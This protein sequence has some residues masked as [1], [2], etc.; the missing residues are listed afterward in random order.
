MDS[1]H[2]LIYG[3]QQHEGQGDD[4]SPATAVSGTPIQTKTSASKR[5]SKK[6]PRSITRQQREEDTSTILDEPTTPCRFSSRLEALYNKNPSME[7]DTQNASTS[8]A[9]SFIL[10]DLPVSQ[11]RDKD[12]DDDDSYAAHRLRKRKHKEDVTRIRRKWQ[13]RR[14]NLT[15]EEDVGNVVTN[16]IKETL[17]RQEQARRK[18]KVEQNV[19]TGEMAQV[20]DVNESLTE[21][22]Y[23]QQG[24]TVPD[25]VKIA[26]RKMVPAEV[27]NSRSQLETK[28]SCSAKPSSPPSVFTLRTWEKHVAIT[29]VKDPNYGTY[30]FYQP[31]SAADL[32]NTVRSMHRRYLYATTARMI[33][34]NDDD[35]PSSTHI[36][37]NRLLTLL[38]KPPPFKEVDRSTL[39]AHHLDRSTLLQLFVELQASHL[40]F[41]LKRSWSHPLQ[42]LHEL[43]LGASSGCCSNMVPPSLIGFPLNN[44][45]ALEHVHKQLQQKMVQ[46]YGLDLTIDTSTADDNTS[47]LAPTVSYFFVPGSVPPTPMGPLDP[48]NI[49]FGPVDRYNSNVQHAPVNETVYQLTLSTLLARLITARFQG[50]DEDERH[51][52]QHLQCMALETIRLN[53]NKGWKLLAQFTSTGVDEVPLVQFAKACH[54]YCSLVANNMISSSE[55]IKEPNDDD[56]SNDSK[57]SPNVYELIEEWKDHNGLQLFSRL[58]ITFGIFRIHRILPDAAAAMLARPFDAVNCRTPLELMQQLLEFMEDSHMLTGVVTPLLGKQ[59]NVIHVSELEYALYQASEYFAKA[60]DRDPTEPSCHEWHLAVLMG[61]MLLCSGNR[62]E[63]EAR[64]HPSCRVNDQPMSVLDMFGSDERST[65]GTHEIRRMLPKFHRLRQETARA[66]HNLLLLALHQQGARSY[67]AVTSFLEWKQGIALMFGA[68]AEDSS[69][70]MFARTRSTH[71]HFASKWAIQENSTLSLDYLHSI[72]VVTDNENNIL[73][74]LATALEREPGCLDSWRNFADKLGCFSP[75]AM[76]NRDTVTDWWG[77]DRQSWW[78]D[79]LLDTSCCG[80]EIFDDSPLKLANALMAWKRRVQ[81]LRVTSKVRPSVQANETES[82]DLTPALERIYRAAETAES[83][84]V[85]LESRRQTCDDELPESFLRV[86]ENSTVDGKKKSSPLYDTTW[87]DDSMLVLCCKLIIRCHLFGMDDLE[88]RRQVRRLMLW[89]L[90]PATKTIQSESDHCRILECL[91]ILRLNVVALC[92]EAGVN[93][94]S[95]SDT[96]SVE[97]F[98]KDSDQR[99]SQSSPS[100]N[101]ASSKI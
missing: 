47:A 36:L 7:Q 73:D 54:S 81:S 98:S 52:Q 32:P 34:S 9:K 67:L 79:L 46:E 8:K 84:S 11:G 88:V 29:R 90:D 89:S 50:D 44:R 53:Q 101:S 35:S 48:T 5:K 99:S 100:G 80:V 70:R 43:G 95:S 71:R 30:S 86:L 38:W 39:N 4:E 58:Q 20:D 18:T 82:I 2:A 19:E 97:S 66:F 49:V 63:D 12:D 26:Y 3:S 16:V 14:Y 62:I 13:K 83:S 10:P 40:Q 94:N 57:S 22:D 65:I 60:V 25:N 41:F 24:K 59:H 92:D 55:S 42:V 45:K 17:T 27:V 72:A 77:R 76:T 56:S 23:W 31:P 6:R 87:M 93:E 51:I 91:Y 33:T 28:A 61:S 1:L 37:L 85:A 21:E 69:L 64:L 78:G 96:A 74:G 68:Q 15:Q 75:T